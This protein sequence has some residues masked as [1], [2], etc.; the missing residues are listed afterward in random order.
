[1][2]LGQAAGPARTRRLARLAARTASPATSARAAA[3]TPSDVT[4]QPGCPLDPSGTGSGAWADV[5]LGMENRSRASCRWRAASAVVCC[6][7]VTGR[8]RQFSPTWPW[9][10]GRR[11]SLPGA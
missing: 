9:V 11:A 8:L 2:A 5:P 1:M 7:E 10:G 3:S 4:S 6:C